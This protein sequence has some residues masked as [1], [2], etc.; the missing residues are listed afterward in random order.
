MDQYGATL[1]S[2]RAGTGKTAL[3]AD[4]ARDRSNVSWFSVE[5]ADIDWREFT[6]GYS[7]SLFG[8]GRFRYAA[9]AD[10]PDSVEISEY[11]TRCF[12]KFRTKRSAAPRLIILDNVHHLFDA[13]WFTY[14]FQQLITSIDESARLLMLCRSKPSAPLW[15]LRS[16]QMLNVIDENMLDLTPEEAV[17][18]GRLRGISDERAHAALKRSYGRVGTF[19]KEIIDIPR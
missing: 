11:L 2:G 12:A 3:A 17:A 6:A 4:F 10:M 16:K 13:R 9:S 5:P 7:A 15:R 1:I 18:V 14:F 8:K 19:L